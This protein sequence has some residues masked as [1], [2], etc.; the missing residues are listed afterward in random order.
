VD[1]C[2]FLNNSNLILEADRTKNAGKNLK[3]AFVQVRDGRV[4]QGNVVE[5]PIEINRKTLK[6]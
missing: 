4:E 3:K 2:R 1:N 5:H 6:F